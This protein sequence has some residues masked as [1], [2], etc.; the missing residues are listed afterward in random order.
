MSGKTGRECKLYYKEGGIA[1][2]GDWT[3]CTNV[4]GDLTLAHEFGDAEV[5]TRSTRYIEHM[6][7]LIDAGIEFQMVWD[8]TDAG[9]GAFHDAHHNDDIIGVAVMD[10]AIATGNGLQF[11]AK[12][13]KFARNE[14]LE[15]VA[16]A[17]VSIKPAYSSTKPRWL[18]GGASPTGGATY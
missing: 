9:F 4:M 17:D 1:A 11:D 7:T 10:G 18:E 12:V 5:K 8:P 14:P 6:S 15:D 13:F 3:E 2:A 16:A